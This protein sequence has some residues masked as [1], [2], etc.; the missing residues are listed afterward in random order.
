MGLKMILKDF[1]MD[2]RRIP[3]YGD[4]MD[5]KGFLKIHTRMGSIKLL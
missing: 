3:K 4:P 2:S 5:F 1:Y